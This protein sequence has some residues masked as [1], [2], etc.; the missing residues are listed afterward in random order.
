MSSILFTVG[1]G[2]IDRVIP[3]TEELLQRYRDDTGCYY[4]D[5]QP[6]TPPIEVVPGDLA[7]ALKGNGKARFTEYR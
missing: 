1:A 2:P 6:V 4:F 7:V 5:Y 3:D